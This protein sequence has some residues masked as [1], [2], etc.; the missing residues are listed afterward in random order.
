MPMDETLAAAAVDLSGRPYCVVNAKIKAERVGNFRW[1]C[2]KIFLEDLQR[3]REPMCIC[4][5]CMAVVASPG[6]GV[7]QGFC[8]GIAICGGAGQTIEK[9]AAEY[10]RAV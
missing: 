2:W 6:G 1:S 3:R 7:V 4:G 10:E 9:C 5:V 8:A